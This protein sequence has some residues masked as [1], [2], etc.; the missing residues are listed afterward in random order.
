MQEKRDMTCRG[1][2]A[3]CH[4]GRRLHPVVRVTKQNETKRMKE[5]KEKEKININ[6]MR[7]SEEFIKH[8]D[9]IACQN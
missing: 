7:T 1:K 9:C 6:S 8:T 4:V 5:I 3:E 2:R